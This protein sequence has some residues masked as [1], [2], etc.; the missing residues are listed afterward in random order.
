MT[1]AQQILSPLVLLLVFAGLSTVLD[2]PKQLGAHPRWSTKVIWIGVPAGLVLHA[3]GASISTSPVI[4]LI[5]FPA[6]TGIGYTIA[7][8]GKNRFAASYAEDTFAGHMWYFGWIATCAFAAAAL[9]SLLR[10][11]QQNR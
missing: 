3:L 7:T 2:L 11:W 6:L 4:R 8:V 1:R 10:Y 5:S 9:I